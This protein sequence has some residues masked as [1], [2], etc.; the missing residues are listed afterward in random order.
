MHEGRN[1]TFKASRLYARQLESFLVSIVFLRNCSRQY[2]STGNRG[3]EKT[4]VKAD[5]LRHGKARGR[6]NVGEESKLRGW[7]HLE[8]MDP[9]RVGRWG[10]GFQTL[11]SGCRH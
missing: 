2:A 8:R 4:E 10:W 9:S 5:R 3:L 6:W 7:S 11:V 1:S